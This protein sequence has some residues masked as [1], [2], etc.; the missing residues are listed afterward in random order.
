MI[1]KA[2]DKLRSEVSVIHRQLTSVLRRKVNQSRLLLLDTRLGDGLTPY[3]LVCGQAAVDPGLEA[4]FED[5][6][7]IE[8]SEG[9]L[10]G[11]AGGDSRS[12]GP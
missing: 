12:R 7:L 9:P 6:R 10:P 2:L 3:D 11:R 1:S 8:D 5:S 4:G